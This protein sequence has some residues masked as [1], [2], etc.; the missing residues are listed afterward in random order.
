MNKR[1]YK[2][3]II[4][5]RCFPSAKAHTAEN[6]KGGWWHKDRDEDGKPIWRCTCCGRATPRQIRMSKRRREIKETLEGLQ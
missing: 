1:I 5:T 6:M 2:R 3:K 4:C